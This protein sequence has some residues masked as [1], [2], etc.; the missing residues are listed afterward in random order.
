MHLGIILLVFG[1]IFISELPD[2]SFLSSLI[3]GSRYPGRYVWLGAAIAFLIHVILAVTAGGLLTL[4][5]HTL[6]E[7]II[8]LSFLLGALLLAFGKHGI[9]PEPK[10]PRQPTNP[11]TPM[12]RVILTAFTITFAGEWGDITQITTVNYTAR[13]HDPWSVAIGAVLA[14]WAV[15]FL[16]IVLGKKLLVHIHPHILQRIAAVI[17]F[18][19]AIASFWKLLAPL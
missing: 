4:L 16:A 11:T 2:K 10:I 9:E 13:Y 5:P 15:T 18:C 19:F 6:V 8:A 14:L 1:V 7:A 3:L 17:L 12:R